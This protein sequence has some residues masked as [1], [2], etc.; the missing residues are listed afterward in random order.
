MK[1]FFK[2]VVSSCFGSCFSM[3]FL[4]VVAFFG[5]TALFGIFIAALFNSE[6]DAGESADASEKE[7]SILVIDL[8]RGFSDMPTFS[9]ANTPDVFS[10]AKGRYGLLDTLFALEAAQTDDSIAGILLLGSSS[11][12]D[13]GFATISEL[14]MG[15]ANFHS[16]SDKPI[17]A[18]LTSPSQKEYLLAGASDEIWLHP[19]AEL[20]LNGISSSGLYFKNALETL[21]IG[22]QITR[23]GTHKSA[24]EPL[25]S[26]SM[27]P[28]DRAQR[29]R[30][31][32]TLWATSLLTIAVNHAPE[33]VSP[34][35]F[36]QTLMK[37]S[38]EQGLLTAQ[39]ALENKL[40]AG[41][42][43]ED[44]IIDALKDLTGE[45]PK[46][47]SFRQ[48]SLEK[49]LRTA[50]ISAE[51]PLELSDTSPLATV[52]A[53]ALKN[54]NAGTQKNIDAD[55]PKLAIVFAEG[56]IVDGAGTAT[57]VGGATLSRDLR[58]LRNDDSV[59]AVVLRV[60]SPG[61]SVFA[62]EQIRREAELLAKKKTL[63]VSMGDCAASGGYWISTPAKKIFASPTTI[64]GSIGVFGVL[65]NFENTAKKIGIGTDA[66]N[67]AP[68]AEID[69]VRRA[70]TT[71]EMDIFQERT[72]QIYEGFLTIV[73]TA[74]NKTREEVD[75]I[76]QGQVWLG[77]DAKNFNLID[78]FG[79]LS[80]AI[81]FAREDAGLADDA[82]ILSVPGEVNRL[83]ELLY[84]FDEAPEEPFA[85][86][87][88]TAMEKQLAALCAD[89]KTNVISQ[90]ILKNLRR[91]MAQLR[92]F[93]DP[94]G[95]YARMPFD[96][97]FE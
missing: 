48:I 72:N 42:A 68:L 58:D 18:F 27:S 23:V 94:L 3:I 77:Y 54:A 97:Q 80:E 24:V 45:D 25:I 32:S 51:P 66:V 95:I 6:K 93:N 38:T 35:E 33:N 89:G 60:N 5:A 53:N 31:V 12:G 34:E 52:F 2:Q 79:G 29:E 84:L 39:S 86:A 87:A 74:R 8:S 61:G 81:A 70:K 9:Q 16:N 36:S 43:Y 76:A 88:G 14:A 46:T 59:K 55:T 56:E 11:H 21:G 82:P 85:R 41:I 26:D 47:H 78:E 90:K 40:V 64:T 63:V 65:F 13:L 71:Q 69:T 92:A 44:E 67:S 1:S 49:Y 57:E 28:E 30:L 73:G 50:G 10:S 83:D 62:S 15:L 19:L 4:S 22:V 96:P 91:A 17:Y 20:P 75:A 37:V 7:K